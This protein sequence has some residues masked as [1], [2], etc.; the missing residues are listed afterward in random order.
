MTVEHLG[1]LVKK[2][3]KLAGLNQTDLAMVSGTATR[4]IS[5]LENGKQSCEIGK[6]MAVC[7]SLGLELVPISKNGEVVRD[8]KN[9]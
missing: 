7:Q 4:F 6:V 3:R 9:T 8:G 1:L 5:N 2:H